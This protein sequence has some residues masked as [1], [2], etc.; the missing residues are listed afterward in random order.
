MQNAQ[1][2]DQRLL[3]CTADNQSSLKLRLEVTHYSFTYLI[4]VVSK[5]NLQKNPICLQAFKQIVTDHKVNSFFIGF[6]RL[7]DN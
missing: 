2:F 1:L 3:F 4:K 5:Q 7:L 6:T